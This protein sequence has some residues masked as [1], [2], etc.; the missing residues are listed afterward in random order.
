MRRKFIISAITAFAVAAIV[1]AHRAGAMTPAISSFKM[2]NPRGHSL[3]LHRPKRVFFPTL[4]PQGL[5]KRHLLEML[6]I[7]ITR[8]RINPCMHLHR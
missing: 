7:R 4:V 6:V 3:F 2:A 8:H 1:A 5:F